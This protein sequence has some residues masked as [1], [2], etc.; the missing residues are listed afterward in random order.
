MLKLLTNFERFPERWRSSSAVEGTARKVSSVFEILRCSRTA[1]FIIINC[2][3]D[4]TLHLAAA[5]LLMPFLRRPILCHDLALRR[6]TRL[7]ARL[8]TPIKRFC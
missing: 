3:A 6:P 5:Y 2:E 8:L 7:R 1:D 4:L